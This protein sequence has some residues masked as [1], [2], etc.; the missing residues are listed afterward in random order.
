MLATKPTSD[1]IVIIELVASLKIRLPAQDPPPDSN[2]ILS[3]KYRSGGGLQVAPR[4]AD[5]DRL[6]IETKTIGEGPKQA[7]GAVVFTP[8]SRFS[9]RST[10]EERGN[11]DSE[12]NSVRSEHDLTLIR[13]TGDPSAFISKGGWYLS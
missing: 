2:R 12:E 4:R 11:F 1:A 3:S 6:H 7:R 13:K 9:W 10:D 8:L 5:G